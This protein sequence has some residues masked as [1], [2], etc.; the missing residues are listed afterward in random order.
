MLYGDGTAPPLGQRSS[1]MAGG[2][3]TD[4]QLARGWYDLLTPYSREN[5]R[6]GNRINVNDQRGSRDRLRQ[7]LT[8]KISASRA[9]QILSANPNDVRNIFEF[10]ARGNMTAEEIDAVAANL[11]AS[12]DRTV[13]GLINVRTAPRAVLAGLPNIQPADVDKIVSGRT[14]TQ[15]GQV[16]W[17]MDALGPAAATRIGSGITTRSFQYSADILAVTGNGRAFQRV[18]LIIDTRNTTPRIYYRRDW[19]DRGWPMDPGV[20]ASLR[21]GMGPG[22]AAIGVRSMGGRT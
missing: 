8:E 9:Q 3:V 12:N 2:F 15:A 1:V 14:G 17:I 4:P 18:R 7:L 20:L 6:D 13:R 19:T 22:S 21:N 16:G 10:F 5:T 11:T